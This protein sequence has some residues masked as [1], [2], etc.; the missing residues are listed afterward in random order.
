MTWDAADGYVLLYGGIGCGLTCKEVDTWSFSNGIWTNLTATTTGSPLFV[1]LAGMAFDP[2]TGKV[3]LFGGYQAGSVDS[4][5]TWSYHAG[6]WTN[7]SST[8]GATPGARVLPA[9][10]TDSTDNEIVMTGGQTPN[11][12]NWDTWT[13]KAGT[14]TNVTSIAGP[15]GRLILPT[16]SDDPPEHGVLLFGPQDG[17]RSPEA[18]LVYSAGT[19]H[20]LTSSL[21]GGSAPILAA[22]AGYLPNLGAAGRVLGSRGQSYRFRGLRV[23]DVGVRERGVEERHGP[24]GDPAG[25]DRR[26]GSDHRPGLGRV[27]D[28]R[29]G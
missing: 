2:S 28:L 5:Y 19:W 1:Y 20:N 10:T 13:F 21:S 3:I 16:A 11:G 18:T 4:D 29:R 17:G 7:L 9:M 6:T 27:P 26:G 12:Y 15:A 25:G 22:T 24:D 14:W 23:A 8:V